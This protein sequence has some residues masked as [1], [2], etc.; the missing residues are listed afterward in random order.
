MDTRLCEE[1]TVSQVLSLLTGIPLDGAERTFASSKRLGE[2]VTGLTLPLEILPDPES[3]DFV[4]FT[5]WVLVVIKAASDKI[6]NQL[7]AQYPTVMLVD[8]IQLEP[9]AR[10]DDMPKVA[11]TF[12]TL[13]AGHGIDLNRKV[14]MKQ[15]A[16]G[17]QALVAA[18]Y[19]SPAYQRQCM[20]QLLQAY[21]AP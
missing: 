15:F 18:K 10:E 20:E 12:K 11:E 3:D 14:R 16:P 17:E 2:F 1:F 5:A 9:P 6:W 19:R 4:T 8:A 13:A 7:Q 21:A